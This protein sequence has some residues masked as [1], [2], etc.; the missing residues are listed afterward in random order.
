RIILP[1]QPLGLRA[2]GLP[3]LGRRVRSA[4]TRS[5]VTGLAVTRF[6]VTRLAGV[7]RHTLAEARSEDSLVI[8]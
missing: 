4:V 3:A 5:A 2:G 7:I 6:A 1:Q 8:G